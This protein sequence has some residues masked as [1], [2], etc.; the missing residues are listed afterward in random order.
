MEKLFK[1]IITV[2]KELAAIEPDDYST[3]S[4]SPLLSW[5]LQLLSTSF[6]V[7]S[8]NKRKTDRWAFL[9]GLFGQSSAYVPSMTQASESTHPRTLPILNSSEQLCSRDKI[10]TRWKEIFNYDDFL[11]ELEKPQFIARRLDILA[12]RLSYLHA[13]I[14]EEFDGTPAILPPKRGSFSL[15]LSSTT[16]NEATQSKFLVFLYLLK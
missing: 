13:L 12:D 6:D 10:F 2:S 16:A 9:A 5:T 15:P 7:V 11:T 3:C 1:F 14:R 8:C 4:N